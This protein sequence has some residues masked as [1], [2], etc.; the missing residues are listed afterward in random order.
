MCGV[1]SVA[2]ANSHP[3][4]D[5]LSRPR[6]PLE[7]IRRV[8]QSDACADIP[9]NRSTE[10]RYFFESCHCSEGMNP[11][12][13][14]TGEE[15]RQRHS[16]LL[17][18][19]EAHVNQGKPKF[20]ICSTAHSRSLA[21]RAWSQRGIPLRLLAK[22]QPHAWYNVRRRVWS[23]RNC[24]LPIMKDVTLSEQAPSSLSCLC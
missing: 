24:I 10:P 5:S 15:Y 14:L 7:K 16:L 21:W 8:F 18:N 2:K 19:T 23:A 22:V 4:S 13:C 12:R 17:S 3:G 1:V 9:A 20:T 11:G 6:V